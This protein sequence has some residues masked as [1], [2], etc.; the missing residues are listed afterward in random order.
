V[1][2]LLKNLLTI[3]SALIGIA[4]FVA[5]FMAYFVTS[6]DR[7]TRQ[8]L[9]GL[10]RPLAPTPLFFRFFFGAERMWAGMS[11]F[12]LDFIWFFGGIYLAFTL[13]SVAN[14]LGG[15]PGGRDG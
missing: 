9:D 11:W 2:T 4:V 5:A 6:G 14:K 13:F 7:S 12:L 3:A 1:R 15:T 8:I 10:G